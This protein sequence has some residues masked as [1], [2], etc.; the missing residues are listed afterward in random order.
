MAPDAWLRIS[1]NKC[2][3]PDLTSS[4]TQYAPVFIE[5]SLGKIVAISFA[6]SNIRVRGARD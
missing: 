1:L 2:S 4:K 3:R 6:Q 5:Q